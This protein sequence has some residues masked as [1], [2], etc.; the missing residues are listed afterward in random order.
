M[1]GIFRSC[2]VL[3][4]D[5]SIHSSS[6]CYSFRAFSEHGSSLQVFSRANLLTSQAKSAGKMTAHKLHTAP[7]K[8]ERDA[9]SMLVSGVVGPGARRQTR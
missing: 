1:S 2:K 7:A 3:Q 9:G 8:D 4:Y 6:F 5:A